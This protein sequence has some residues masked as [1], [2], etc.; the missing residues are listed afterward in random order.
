MYQILIIDDDDYF[1]QSLKN[2]LVY[3]GFKVDTCANPVLAMQYVQEK[4][5]QLILLDVKMPGM[6]GIELLE[7]IRTHNQNIPVVMVSGQSNIS[8][9]VEAIKKGAFDF[10]EKPIDPQKLQVALKNALERYKLWEDRSRLIEELKK[11]YAIVG[12]SEAINAIIRRIE[13]VADLDAKVLITGETGTGKELVARALHLASNRSSGPFVKLNCAA[14]PT[15]LLESELFGHKKGAFTGAIKDQIGKF[16][17]ADGGTLFLDEIGDMDLVLQ[18]KLLHVLQDNE[19]MMLGAH[20]SIKV[21]VRIITATNQNI[22]ELIAEGKFRRD[23]FHRINVV[24]IHIP[25]L[26]ERVEDIEPLAIH[27][28][29]EFA[30]TYN[31]KVTGFEPEVLNALKKYSWPG[32]VRELRNVVEKMV[33]FARHALITKN[34]LKES[35]LQLPVEI[36][37]AVEKPAKGKLKEEMERHERELILNA[38]KA[39][40]GSNARAAKILGIDRSSLFKK[41]KK[42]G[43]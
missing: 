37:S 36:V 42:L 11:K 35:L 10:V 7:K 39:A 24:N 9:A 2:L 33:I 1:L 6:D 5:Y 13:Q 32:N 23:L 3:K 16:Q 31:K 43:I 21:N 40:N 25:P 29:K 14:I 41:R 12:K 18:A 20:D 30:E 34:D 4:R 22:N 28:L 15:E 38:L 17:A 27:F 8:I 26:R 19:F